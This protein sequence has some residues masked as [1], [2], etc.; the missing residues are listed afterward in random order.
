M[1]NCFCRMVDQQKVLSFS[2]TQVHCQRFSSLQMSH[3]LQAVF[4]PV[5][6]LSSDF[7]EKSCAVVIITK[8]KNHRKDYL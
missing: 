5:Q 6:N 1:M 8:P 7:I 4:E 3:M 2:S